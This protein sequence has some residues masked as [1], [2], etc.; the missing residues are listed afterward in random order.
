MPTITTARASAR[1]I[2]LPPEGQA[3]IPA[4]SGFY[5]NRNFIDKHDSR[6]LR[7]R[8]DHVDAFPEPSPIAEFHRSRNGCKQRVIFAEPHIASRLVARPALPDDDGS[9]RD[10]LPR[11]NFDA[12]TLR[13]RIASVF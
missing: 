8:G 6:S 11:E 4:V 3:A 1:N 9:A 5:R 12:Q 7:L 13:I 2:L 10:K